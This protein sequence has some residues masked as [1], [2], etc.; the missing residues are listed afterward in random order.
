AYYEILAVKISNWAEADGAATFLCSLIHKNFDKD[1]DTVGYIK[2]L[3]EKGDV[4]TYQQLRNEYLM[5][6]TTNF[7][8]KVITGAKGLEL[9]HNAAPKGTEWV[10]VQLEDFIGEGE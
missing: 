5:P 7:E 2:A 6:Q 10:P 1:P 8:F 9:Y 3:K 4:E